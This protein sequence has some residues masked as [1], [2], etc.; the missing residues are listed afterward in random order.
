MVKQ[1]DSPSSPAHRDSSLRQQKQTISSGDTVIDLG[2]S[3]RLEEKQHDAFAQAERRLAAV[4][5]KV[6][7]LSVNAGYLSLVALVLQ[8]SS[9]VLMTRW[10]SAHR[11]VP[12][13]TGF[14][15][16]CVEL[17]KMMGCLIATV[18]EL[19]E[20]D[21]NL[22]TVPHRLFDL[23]F[24][25]DT[26]KLCIPA[27]LFTLQNYLVFISL[28]NLDAMTFQV[29]SQVKLLFA[30][31]F[32]VWL[33]NRY[34]SFVQWA[35][36]LTLT[37]G[38]VLAGSGKTRTES[39]ANPNNLVGVV[40]CLISGTSSSFAGV[41]FE[42][43]LK[44]TPPS[45]AIRNIQIGFPALVFC[46][47]TIFSMERGLPFVHFDPLQG[48]DFYSVLLILNHAVGG[49][50]VAIVVKYA[51]NILKGFATGIAIIISGGYSTIVWGF[52]P[53]PHFILGCG[54]VAVGT[55]T[56]HSQYDST[57]LRRVAR[58][59]PGGHRMPPTPAV[60]IQLQKSTEMDVMELDA[61]A[62]QP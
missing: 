21:P 43:I 51:D 30:A 58:L 23:F 17:V 19:L 3:V 61:T 35:S 18:K 42:K 14:M 55:V 10:S 56:Y 36:I 16:L 8:N 11:R 27:G 1:E 50:L 40:S 29:L 28:G 7:C 22:R 34:L 32:S 62:E 52:A 49:I 45:V 26:L 41:Y 15:V 4:K 13:H 46:L 48:F 6:L 20:S 54:L 2:R 9:L 37:F 5:T 53:S 33:L 47:L 38:I 59:C 57:I 39:N 31:V 24:S 44:G 25:K 60:G 12:L